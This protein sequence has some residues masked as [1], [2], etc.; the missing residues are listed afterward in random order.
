[1]ILAVNGAILWQVRDE[2]SQYDIDNLIVISP[3]MDDA[4]ENGTGIVLSDKCKISD[5]A[6]IA[7]NAQIVADETSS[8]IIDDYAVIGEGCA[9]IASDN[10]YIHIGA[11]SLIDKE[12]KI[13]AE[14]TSQI[15]LKNQVIVGKL[16]NVCVKIDS[17]VRIGE[18][19]CI[20]DSGK[21][22]SYNQGKIIIGAN[23]TFCN[24]LYMES[25]QSQIKIG[26]DC[27]FS[28]YI[29]LNVGSHR[30]IEKSSDKDV[31]NRMPI[32]IGNHVWC[33]MIVTLLPG[34]EVEDGSVIGAST[35]VNKRIPTNSTC[36]GNPL[37][38]LRKDIAWFRG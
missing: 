6:Y 12:T 37:R 24:N 28:Y 26:T 36:A 30:L 11:R 3:L 16:C 20:G 18:N 15:E 32:L 23:T 27:M 25:E 35:I 1:M 8:N 34:C 22:G 4:F 2:I 13:I 19:I 17:M 21:I 7:E 29:K 9:V 14:R 10:S 31:T 5:K 38:L 33:G